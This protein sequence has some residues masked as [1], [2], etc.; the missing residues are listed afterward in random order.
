MRALV[1]RAFSP[2]S[3]AE[4][5]GDAAAAE[6]ASRTSI[7]TDDG[8]GSG[9]VAVDKS[10]DGGQSW[11]GAV[12]VNGP[13]KSIAGMRFPALAATKALAPRLQLVPT[14]SQSPLAAFDLAP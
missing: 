8:L 14:N 6:V 1:S 10:C 2:R 11:S 4:L 13:E 5:V 3:I 7:A 9:R 12:L